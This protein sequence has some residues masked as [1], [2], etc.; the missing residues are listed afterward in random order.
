MLRWFEHENKLY[1]NIDS[2]AI[3]KISDSYRV[4]DEVKEQFKALRPML[5]NR[6]E[7]HY[8]S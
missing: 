7:K 3:Q 5:K 1:Y 8:E 6:E 4:S 2:K